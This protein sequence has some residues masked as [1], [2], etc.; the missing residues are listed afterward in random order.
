MKWRSSHKNKHLLQKYK[1]TPH[2]DACEDKSQACSGI[3]ELCD[4]ASY[5]QTLETYCEKTCG[6]CSSD[7]AV[8]PETGPTDDGECKDQYP[9]CGN[10]DFMCNQEV[11]ESG[12]PNE[13][14]ERYRGLCA[15][16]CGLCPESESV[17]PDT[18]AV[19]V[20]Q[21]AARVTEAPSSVENEAG[22]SGCSDLAKNCLQ[23][24]NF[25]TQDTTIEMMKTQCRD[26][27][28]FCKPEETCA[29][30]VGQ[31]CENPGVLQFCHNTNTKVP[32]VCKRTCHLCPG[33]EPLPKPTQRATT[34]TS[35]TTTTTTTTTTT[36]KTTPQPTTPKP[37]TVAAVTEGQKCM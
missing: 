11:G 8:Q 35:S 17:E 2:L 3:A 23:L 31:G 28:G 34:T 5:T 4:Q 24:K 1:K 7:S 29:D 32:E 12:A 6:F 15:M 22:I 10:M 14:Q 30:T 13:Y 20:S 16:T 25:C 21:S 27:C 9:N 18:T 33:Q 19:Y 26:T 36:S 37:T